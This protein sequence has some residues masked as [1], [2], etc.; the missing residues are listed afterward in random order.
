VF[1]AGL[2]GGW[3]G[4]KT[5]FPELQ[6]TT[7]TPLRAVIRYKKTS[8]GAD[9][10]HDALVQ[11]GT[12]VPRRDVLLNLGLVHRASAVRGTPWRLTADGASVLRVGP[13]RAS[14]RAA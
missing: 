13:P 2:P 3:N 7:H 8:H 14:V 10:V 9:A 1:A 11:P 12:F 5:P 6:K 4:F